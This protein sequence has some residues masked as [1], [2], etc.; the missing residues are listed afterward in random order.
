LV[1]I[2]RET[3]PLARKAR[4]RL[5]DLRG[6]DFIYTTRTG[7]TWQYLQPMLQATGVQNSG[8]EVSEVSTM[9]GLVSHGFGVGIVAKFAIPL[10][11]KKGLAA[12]P[13][14]DRHAIRPIFIARRRRRS[15]SLAAQSLWDNLIR[16]KP[17]VK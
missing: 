11:Q 1:L 3:D 10:C 17:D 12:V 15:L 7:T 9:A 2:C 5:N 4:I 13:I 16:T 8:F 14:A 6:R